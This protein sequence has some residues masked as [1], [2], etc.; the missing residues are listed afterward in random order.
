MMARGS[1]EIDSSES[2]R[3]SP[4]AA[5][6]EQRNTIDHGQRRKVVTEQLLTDIFEGR[7]QAGERLVIT[8]LAERFGVSQSPIR[9]ALVT[10]E[11]IGIVDIEVNRGAVVRRVTVTEVQELSQVRR[12][13][14]CTAVRLACGRIDTAE[15]NYLADMF[16]QVAQHRPSAGTLEPA[17]VKENIDQARRLDSRLHDLIAESCGNRF[18][19][20]E[21]GRLK[22][23]VRSFRDVAWYRR[24]TDSDP[25]RFSKEAREH[26][27]IVEALRDGDPGTAARAMSRHIRSGARYWSRGLP[28]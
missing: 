12:A 25:D 22:L 7:L 24:S 17:E 16:R 28:Q 3:N 13:L 26:L 10:L 6:Q 27:A 4:E 2:R 8:A 19:S 18:L 20:R 11:G 5:P 15:L 9:E 1:S 23:L 14:E 21:L